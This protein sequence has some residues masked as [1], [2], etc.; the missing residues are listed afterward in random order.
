MGVGVA[1]G[2]LGALV[3]V[4][5]LDGKVVAHLILVLPVLAHGDD[6]A[7]ELVAHDDRMVRHVVGDPLVLLAL[8]RRFVG[9]HAHAV[10]DNFDLYA[11]RP[12]LRQ[13]HVLQPQVHFSVKTDCFR[14]HKNLLLLKNIK[15]SVSRFFR[16]Q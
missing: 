16:G 8:H 9:G 5:G 14:I 13:G 12:H 3:V 10:R 6:I 7:A 4:G 2:V 11:V 1:G 15:K